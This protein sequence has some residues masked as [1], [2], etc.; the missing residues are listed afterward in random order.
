MKRLGYS[1]Q[2][3]VFFEFKGEPMRS[4]LSKFLIAFV[5][6]GM[7][8]AFLGLEKAIAAEPYPYN[9]AQLKYLFEGSE[10]ETIGGI[11]KSPFGTPVPFASLMKFQDNLLGG[12]IGFTAL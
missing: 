10:I 1:G 7:I 9:S 6:C 8:V 5:A 12:Y 4:A 2:F 11:C 3:P